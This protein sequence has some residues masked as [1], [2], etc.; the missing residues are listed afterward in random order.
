MYRKTLHLRERKW[1]VAAKYFIILS[2]FKIFFVRQFVFATNKALN[3]KYLE[4]QFLTICTKK[5][6]IV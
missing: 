3:N 1:L 6:I 2:D 5:A 4:L